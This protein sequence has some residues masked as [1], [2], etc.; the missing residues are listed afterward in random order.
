MRVDLSVL[1]GKGLEKPM[2]SVSSRCW[3]A[4]VNC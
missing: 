1:S 4:V 2:R 3:L